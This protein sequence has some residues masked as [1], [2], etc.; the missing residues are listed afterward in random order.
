MINNTARVLRE[1]DADVLCLVEVENL[2]TLRRF[3]SEL[4]RYQR[5]GRKRQYSGAMLVES[6]DPRGIDLG[7]LAQ[8]G[9][10][11]AS[12]SRRPGASPRSRPR[13]TTCSAIWSWSRAI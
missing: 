2:P 13:A 5:L 12:G 8:P 9:F 4:L 10:E 3:S 1:I 6:K 7:L 11:I